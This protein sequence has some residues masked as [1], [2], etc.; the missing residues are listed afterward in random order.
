[1][2]DAA[3]HPPRLANILRMN[4]GRD[5]YS[6]ELVDNF[7]TV[8]ESVQESNSDSEEQRRP[9]SPQHLPIPHHNSHETSTASGTVTLDTATD[10]EWIEPDPIAAILEAVERIRADQQKKDLEEV[11]ALD[12]ELRAAKLA[13]SALP[14]TAE[15]LALPPLE[16]AEFDRCWEIFTR[17]QEAADRDAA[18]AEKI[19]HCCRVARALINYIRDP[20]D[21]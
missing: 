21:H 17:A 3:R 5:T 2:F 19:R 15:V 10:I 4:G 14:L 8:I 9:K 7:M 20:P 11:F 16:R 1:M 18:E 12:E 13:L 6:T